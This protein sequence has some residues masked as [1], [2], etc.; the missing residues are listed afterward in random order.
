MTA[1]CINP[2]NL[3]EVQN[4]SIAYESGVVVDD[5]S[6]DVRRGEFFCIVGANG[7]GKSTLIRGILGLLPIL[8]GKIRMS[9]TSLSSRRRSWNSRRQ[10]GR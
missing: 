2:A 4:L 6:F 7:S 9:A 5:V 1:A 3:L 10:H 8:R